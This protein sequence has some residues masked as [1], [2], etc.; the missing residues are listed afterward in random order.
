VTGASKGLGKAIAIALGRA[1]YRVAVNYRSDEAGAQQTV[2]AITGNGGTA[3]AFAADVTDPGAVRGLIA[4][5]KQTW[6]PVEVL[7][8]NATGPQPMKPVEEYTWQEYQDQ[9]DFFVKAPVL[10]AQATLADMKAARWGRVIHIGSEV[11]NLGNANFSAYVAAK[12]AMLGLTR[13]WANEFGPWQITVNLV[14][15]GW[16]PVERHADM[17]PE[18]FSAYSA[19]VPLRRQGL[20]EDVAASVVYL[21]GDG[22]NFVTGQCLSVNGGKTF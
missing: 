3:R 10:L 1:G 7:V 12:A 11:V 4:A 20:P 5:V 6:G 14:A 18:H 2:A 15:P 19:S 22:A 8:N 17:A 21:A 13:S 9:L 16:I